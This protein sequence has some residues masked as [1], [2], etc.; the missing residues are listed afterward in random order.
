MECTEEKRRNPQPSLVLHPASV[1]VESNFWLWLVTLQGEVVS[2]STDA[3][4]GGVFFAI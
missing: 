4:T 2:G 3:C 1:V